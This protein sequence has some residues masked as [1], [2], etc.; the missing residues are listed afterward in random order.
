M[1]APR[2]A[3]LGRLLLGTL[4]CREPNPAYF[5]EGDALAPAPVDAATNDTQ[6]DLPA[7]VPSDAASEAGLDGPPD[8]NLSAGLI[9]YWKLDEGAGATARDSSGKGND[10]VL[11]GNF[12]WT[13]DAF[14]PASFVNPGSFVFDGVTTVAVPASPLFFPDATQS[15]TV[16]AWVKV[17]DLTAVAAV[18]SS[19]DGAGPYFTLAVDENEIPYMMVYESFCNGADMS[20]ASAGGD[21]PLVRDVWHHLAGVLDRGS[22][23]VSIY[24]DGARMTTRSAAE[25]GDMSCTPNELS[26]GFQRGQ[27]FWFVGTID[28]VRIY[29][30]A[31]SGEEIAGL[32]AG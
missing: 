28:D 11:W 4:G 2:L 12:A 16:A 27:N 1:R 23:T 17:G 18:V 29:D 25:V 9:G 30:R 22:K 21:N 32:H 20:N 31:L 26:I 8:V 10:G 3:V 13:N 14:A 15:V 7:T 24:V 5:P 19:D 6:G